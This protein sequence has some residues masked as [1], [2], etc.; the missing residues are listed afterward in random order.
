MCDQPRQVVEMVATV[1]PAAV[2]MDIVMQPINGWELLMSLKSDPRTS[3]IPVIV[4]TIVDQPGT[5]VLLGAD[6]YIV[7]PVQKPTLMAAIERCLNNRPR[8][9]SVRP[10]LVV[11]DDTPTREFITELISKSGYVVSS[12]SDGE[13]A[14]LRVADSIPELVILDLM[15]P[16]VSGLELLAEWRADP[17]LVD[18]PVF[19]LTSKDLSTEETEYIRASTGAL[20]QK[21]EP[22]QEA[23]LR[24]L[25]RALTP[26]LAEN[27]G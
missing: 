19:V 22:W 6:E 9:R 17:S 1:Q 25:H 14:R 13:E 24:Q 8:F 20:F 10:I 15:L 16:K 5:G 7:K 2:T 27:Q 23:L 11:E 21:Q 26:A 3:H 4:I 18:L 12:A